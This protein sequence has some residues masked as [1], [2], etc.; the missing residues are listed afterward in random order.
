MYVHSSHQKR[1]DNCRG[2]RKWITE[3]TQKRENIQ[4]FVEAYKFSG[5]KKEEEPGTDRD[6]AE[7]VREMG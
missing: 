2:Q 5:D 7:A 1:N 3:S 4:I 6:G